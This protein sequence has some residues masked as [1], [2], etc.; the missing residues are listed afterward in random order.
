MELTVLTVDQ[1]Q[2]CLP[3]ARRERLEFFV[4]GINETFE[5]FEIDT[6]QRMAMFLAQTAHESANFSAVE[7]NLNYSAKGLLGTWPK[8]FRGV[9]NQYARKPQQ[10][11]N[12]AYC[13]RM[14]NGSESSGD[15]WKYRGRGLIQ[16]TGQD[17]YRTCGDALNLNL[18]DDPDMASKNPAAV[19]SAGWFWTTR[20]L[21]E[22]SD[23]GDV[24]K[25]TKV[26]N[27]GSN[28]LLDRQSKYQHIINVL[29][30]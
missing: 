17:N 12:R 18:L 7:E 16:L 26:I 3:N 20:R 9:E 5:Q 29:S 30:A 28:G 8:R 15:G 2:E 10:I 13:D 27:G 14:G 6:P 11:A 25:A 23:S 4:D 1:L 21:N 22:I 19:L 24:A